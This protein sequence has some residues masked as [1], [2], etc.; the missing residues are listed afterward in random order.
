MTVT[1]EE[2]LQ[3]IHTEPHTNYVENASAEVLSKVNLQHLDKL[4]AVME[5]VK[6]EA[7]NMGVWLEADHTHDSCG[8]VA[9]MAG[10]AAVHPLTVADGWDVYV[11]NMDNDDI[12]HEDRVRVPRYSCTQ[13]LEHTGTDAVMVY[14]NCTYGLANAL[15]SA[16]SDSWAIY[17]SDRLGK[18][19]FTDPGNAEAPVAPVDHTVALYRLRLLREKAAKVQSCL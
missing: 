17:L 5:S 15:V 1:A 2:I 12:P 13:H 4:I 8:T 16:P 3:H 14:L 9:C 19:I 7:V 10:W 6:P 18:D 11:F